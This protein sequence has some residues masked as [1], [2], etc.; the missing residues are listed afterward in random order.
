MLIIVLFVPLTTSRLSSTDRDYRTYRHRHQKRT[1]EE[2]DRIKR[3]RGGDREYVLSADLQAKQ[4]EML[5]KRYGGASRAGRAASIIQ[6]SVTILLHILL[7]YI[8]CAQLSLKR[9]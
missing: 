7:N 4:H 3:S 6:A 2:D 8:E 1:V 5:E 9:L